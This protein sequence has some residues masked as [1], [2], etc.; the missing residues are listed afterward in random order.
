MHDDSP[1][2]SPVPERFSE[3][4]LIDASPRAV[5]EYLTDLDGMREWMGD[6][7]MAIEVE[8]RW[9]VG[10]SIVV[11]GL[12]HKQFENTGVVLRFEPPSALSYTHRS[13]LSHLSDTPDSYT[14]LTFTLT[15]VDHHTALTVVA[16]HF[17]TMAIYRHL[18]FYWA[19]TLSV[20]KRG[21]E[22]PRGYAAS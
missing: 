4:V 8:T 17:P 16:A 10:S 12:H 19:G 7:A 2:A 13:S 1:M 9:Q 21:M 14:T 6:P 18:A 3:T 20:I 22:S 5:W 15:P 11:R